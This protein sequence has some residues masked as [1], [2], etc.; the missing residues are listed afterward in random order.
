[1]LGA[2]LD[3]VL[4]SFAA[5]AE[6]LRTFGFL[7][8]VVQAPRLLC[9]GLPSTVVSHVETLLLNVGVECLCRHVCHEG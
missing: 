1:M 7:F 2:V 4:N 5:R 6:E 3:S 9:I 8:V